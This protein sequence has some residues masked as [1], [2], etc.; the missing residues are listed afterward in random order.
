MILWRVMSVKLN[1]AKKI[2]GLEIM[3]L[4]CEKMYHIPKRTELMSQVEI[5]CLQGCFRQQTGREDI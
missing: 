2:T 5:H 3:T 1:I 4:I